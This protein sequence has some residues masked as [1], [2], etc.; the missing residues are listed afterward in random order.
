[1][2]RMFLSPV[3]LLGTA[4]TPLPA[5]GDGCD[6]HDACLTC[7]FAMCQFDLEPIEDREYNDPKHARWWVVAL[8]FLD[9][10]DTNKTTT[11]IAKQFFTTEFDAQVILTAARWIRNKIDAEYD[12]DPFTIH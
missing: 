8:V 10:I 1:M 12:A 9:E 3:D 7:P 5:S 2:R 11:E 4:A 6:L